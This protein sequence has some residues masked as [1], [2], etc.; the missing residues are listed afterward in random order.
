MKMLHPAPLSKVLWLQSRAFWASRTAILKIP[1]LGFKSG[2]LSPQIL[3]DRDPEILN[4]D[5]KSGILSPQIL[6]TG[7]LQILDFNSKSGILRPA[8]WAENPKLPGLAESHPQYIKI[9]T[10][11]KKIA[12]QRLPPF[13][14][15]P[16]E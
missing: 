12:V 4:F 9:S 5:S 6:P 15:A 14:T 3:P 7:I 8:S 10:L 1:T 13:W 2:I 16:S 11:Y